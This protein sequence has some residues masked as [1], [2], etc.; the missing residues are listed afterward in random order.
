[1]LRYHTPMP[2]A[3]TLTAIVTISAIISILI[4]AA[5]FYLYLAALLRGEVTI[6]AEGGT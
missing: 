6:A 3:A 4:G 2:L 1:M 5:V